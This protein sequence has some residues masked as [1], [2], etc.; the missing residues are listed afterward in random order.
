MS[1]TI[2]TNKIE[3]GG[4][5]HHLLLALQAPLVNFQAETASRGALIKAPEIGQLGHSCSPVPVSAPPLPSFLPIL[6]FISQILI[7]E[8]GPVLL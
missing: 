6:D 3:I 1:L 4:L 5:N 8:R 2:S 7:Q